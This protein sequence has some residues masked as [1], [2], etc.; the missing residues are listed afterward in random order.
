MTSSPIL[1][2]FGRLAQ[3]V[4]P[5]QPWAHPDLHTL[6]AHPELWPPFVQASAVA[7]RYLALLSPLAWDRFPERNLDWQPTPVPY[8]ALA[9]ACLISSTSSLFQWTACGNTWWSTLS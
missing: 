8:A 9:A 5:R 7:R 4:R 1:P 6:G 3:P 2:W